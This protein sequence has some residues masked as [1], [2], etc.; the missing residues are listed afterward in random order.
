MRDLGKRAGCREDVVASAR[1]FLSESI[2]NGVLTAASDKYCLLV[3]R[4]GHHV[5]TQQ[6]SNRN[7][8][9]ELRNAVF[10]LFTRSN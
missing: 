6:Q 4:R 10:G 1:E 9:L 2:A 3:D 5:V 7:Q 8:D